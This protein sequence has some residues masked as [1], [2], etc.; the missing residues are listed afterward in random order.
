MTCESSSPGNRSTFPSRSTVHQAP[1]A[2]NTRSIPAAFVLNQKGEVVFREIG[3]RNWDTD[4]ARRFL[5]SLL[6]KKEVHGSVSGR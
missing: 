3:G 6:S 5:R 2:F 4:R 1:K